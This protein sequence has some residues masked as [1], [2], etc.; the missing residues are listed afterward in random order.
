MADSID[1]D[2]LCVAY[3][4]LHNVEEWVRRCARGS[5]SRKEQGRLAAER[6]ALA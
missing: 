1:F 3:P 6:K 4:Q 2:A 5:L